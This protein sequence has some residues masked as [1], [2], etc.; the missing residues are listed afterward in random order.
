MTGFLDELTVTRTLGSGFSS[1]VKLAFD[2]DSY[3]AYACKILSMEEKGR[4][5]DLLF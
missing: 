3:T 5:L 4:S 1:V 2:P